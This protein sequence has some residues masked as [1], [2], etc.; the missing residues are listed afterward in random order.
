MILFE[1]CTGCK[2]KYLWFLV[3]QREFKPNSFMPM[4][5]SQFKMCNKCFKRTTNYFKNGIGKTA[6]E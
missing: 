5:K 2:T 1:K 4:V 3:K 6:T